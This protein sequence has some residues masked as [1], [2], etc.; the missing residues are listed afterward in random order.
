METGKFVAIDEGILSNKCHSI[1]QTHAG[2]TV[3]V[4]KGTG[5]DGSDVTANSNGSHRLIVLEDFWKNGRNRLLVVGIGNGN[6]RS[7]ALIFHDF[8][9]C[10][11]SQTIDH[12]IV[13]RL[14]YTVVNIHVF[15]RDRHRIVYVVFGEIIPVVPTQYALGFV[16]VHV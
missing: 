1:R 3:A 12:T 2:Q 9:A 13:S 4:L 11:T 7:I 10:V 5:T 16:P 14:I 15:Q 6:R 8:I